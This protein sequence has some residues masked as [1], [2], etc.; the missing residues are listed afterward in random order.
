LATGVAVQRLPVPEPLLGVAVS[1]LVPGK[2]M[3]VMMTQVIPT[4]REA[5][6]WLTLALIQARV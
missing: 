1:A 2:D 5:G 3:N 6:R 4:H